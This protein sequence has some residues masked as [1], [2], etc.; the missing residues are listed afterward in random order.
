MKR[1]VYISLILSFVIIFL[2]Q[3]TKYLTRSNLS[4]GESIRIF[5]FFQLT[6]VQNTGASFGML[7]GNNILLLFVAVVAI[8]L[9][10]YLY[11]KEEK[12]SYR[13]A[14]SIFFA[15]IVGNLI[16]RIAFGSVTDML[17]FLIWPVFNVADIALNIGVF[18]LLYLTVINKDK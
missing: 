14:Y 7:Q 10:G 2:D 12:D 18:M 5:P 9:V 3:F 13:L 1:V 11:Y 17:D 4:L 15:G 16:D 8:V 6:H